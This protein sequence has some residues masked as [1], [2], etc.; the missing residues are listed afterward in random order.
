MSGFEIRPAQYVDRP[1][2]RRVVEAAF[3]DQ[4]HG[5]PTWSRR[6]T[7]RSVPS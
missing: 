7:Q 2:V 1:A 6:W 4:G 5:S 3:G